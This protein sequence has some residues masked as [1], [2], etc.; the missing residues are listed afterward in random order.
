LPSE[1]GAAAPLTVHNGEVHDYLVMTLDF[2]TPKKVK[3]LM[4]EF[5]DEIL[6]HLRVNINGTSPTPAANH[7]FIVNTTNPASLSKLDAEYFHHFVAQ[8]S[9]LCKLSSHHIQTAPVFLCTLVMTF[10]LRIS[11][12]D[13]FF[14]SD[15]TNSV[16]YQDYKNRCIVRE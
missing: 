5:L 13:T 10:F 14:R 1:F 4:A 3:T 16:I 2:G 15:C 12:Q 6:L 7:F 11:E 9:Y 8:L